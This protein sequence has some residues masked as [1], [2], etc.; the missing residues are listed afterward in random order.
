MN[1]LPVPCRR[2][3]LR[4]LALA[5]VC[6]PLAALAQLP[7]ELPS[8]PPPSLKTVPV[9]L[10]PNLP[11]AVT[12]FQAA[13]RLG[14]ALFWD[15]QVGSDGVQAC[16]SCHFHAGADSRF[17][18]QINPGSGG[19][20]STLD[21]GSGGP[22]CA[23]VLGDF[24]FRKLAVPDDNES[25]VVSDTDDVVSSQGVFQRDF[26]QVNPGSDVDTGTN[27]PD[28]TFQVGG[29]NTRRVEPRNSP[30]VINSVFLHRLFWDGRAN[31]SF[32]GQ[33]PF[34][35]TD[36]GATVLVK[37]PDGTVVAERVLFPDAAT[38]SQSVGPPRSAV[39][40]S[41]N[42]RTFDDLGK[43]MLP[44]R[45]LRGSVAGALEGAD[46]TFGQV[47]DPTDSVLGALSRAPLPGLVD[48]A[49]TY[50]DLV[51][52]AFDSK[53]WSGAGD[54]GGFT[55]MEKNF[56]LFFGLAV[57]CYE[58]TLVSDDSPYDRFQD[59]GGEGGSNSD[60]LTAQQKLGMEVFFNRGSCGQ[61]H[62]GPEFAGAA[63][64]VIAVEGLL[65]RMLMENSVADESLTMVTNSPV[66][67]FDQDD[68]M[69][70]EQPEPPDPNE[71]TIPFDPR[72]KYVEIRNPSGF[73]SPIAWS[74]SNFNVPLGQCTPID[75]RLPM[76]LGSS[77]APGAGV[78]AEMRIRVEADCGVRFRVSLG[79]EWPGMPAGNY[80][81]YVGGAFVGVIQMPQVQPPAVYD[82]GFYNI[83]VRPTQEDL[84]NGGA[85][86]FGPFALA[87]RA[88]AGANVDG[89]LLQPPVGATERIA[90][91]GAFKAPSLRNIELTGPYMHNGGFSTLEQVVDFYVGGAH[92]FVQNLAD[93][94]PEVAGVGG[95]SAERKAALVAFLIALTDERVR[96]ERA[97]F[98]HPRLFVPDGHVG[99]TTMVTPVGDGTAV[100]TMLEV[101][102]V[103]AAGGPALRTFEEQLGASLALAPPAGIEVDEI[104]E[105]EAV[106]L[107]SLS[108]EPRYDVRVRFAV[109]NPAQ[110]ELVT[111]EV[112]FTPADWSTP[113]AVRVR[114]REDWLLDGDQQV[115]LVVLPA[116]SADATFNGWDLPDLAVT[117]RD[118]GCHILSL[119]LEAESAELT[120][121]AVVVADAARSGGAFVRWPDASGEHTV[122]DGGSGTAR[123][124]FQLSSPGTYRILALENAPDNRADTLWVRV[125][126][127]VWQSW[128]LARM[129]WMPW[130]WDSVNGVVDPMSWQLAAGPHVLEI[131]AQDDG[132]GLD[133]LVIT[134][135]PAF[136]P[137]GGPF[138]QRQGV[139]Y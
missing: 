46:G 47:V 68:E 119:T 101:P 58:S 120:A 131:Q 117:V 22:N 85:G 44:L 115:T 116:Q 27:V 19:A 17:R 34:G 26:V 132:V 67:A 32:N 123:F 133:K 88:K 60:A 78:S 137:S 7:G 16:A 102:A 57:L 111:Q 21:G 136:M 3:S 54:F 129:Q 63:Q 109:S 92:F 33:N 105:T 53:L 8:T 11:W 126:G 90:V 107:V 99:D 50:A 103:G 59:G 31:N 86:P 130:I 39:E 94:D 74:F 35:D 30:T 66:A 112:V 2:P 97:P 108:P 95:M 114:A 45:P 124:Q 122:P 49:G 100:T 79:W 118:S 48:A 80:R 113:R 18:N 1:T 125:D 106:A 61:C 9:P 77:A 28:P 14:K 98:D 5:L 6:L 128:Q 25:A 13:V 93:L 42:G 29:I 40:M 75:Q 70:G 72:G 69:P 23:L 56:S 41:H 12:D 73:G 104:G 64:S 121:P 20:F 10:P 43:K 127:G 84:G 37:Q 55:Q 38:A 135:D 24:P 71:V 139:V 110:V 76:N 81:V 134:N 15:M 62:A 91:N 4:L 96:H 83:G 51:M 52:A 36:P 65:E 89:G 138:N 87:A 82:L